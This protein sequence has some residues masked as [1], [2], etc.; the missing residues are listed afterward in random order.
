MRKSLFVVIGQLFIYLS[1]VA[2][3]PDHINYQCGNTIHGRNDSHHLVEHCA[4]EIL[5]TSTMD[6][7]HEG[8]IF[9]GELHAD[10]IRIEAGFS[11]VR[12]LPVTNDIH[13][14][15]SYRHKHRTTTGGNGNTG[16]R[17]QVVYD[18]GMSKEDKNN[19][20]K[21]Y[22]NPVVDVLQIIAPDDM[23]V[24]GYDLI[25][26]DGKTLRQEVFPSTKEFSFSTS[27]LK[28]GIYFIHIQS[29]RGVSYHKTILK[30]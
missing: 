18:I 4:D 15:L 8:T 6:E 24:I 1:S 19:Q 27:S 26:T 16:S 22:P 11:K 30:H 7:G 3:D 13:E 20:L 9:T 12:I 5:I 25:N 17:S 29:A 14:F 2:Q 21:L 23:K 28:S 10:R